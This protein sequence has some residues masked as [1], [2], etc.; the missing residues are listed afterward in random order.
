MS[1][2]HIVL[3]RFKPEATP[4]EVDEAV[5][6]FGRLPAEIP[7]IVGFECG[8]NH[9]PEQLDKGFTHAF[10]VSFADAAARDAY[11]PHPAHQAFV[12]R[13]GGLID[14]VLVFDYDVAASHG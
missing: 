7:G 1:V 3:F 6:H 5:M 11:L 12:A 8:T 13:I 14:D 10:V 9:S 2:R 4:R